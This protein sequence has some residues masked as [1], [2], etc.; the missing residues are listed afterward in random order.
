MLS[1]YIT[2]EYRGPGERRGSR[3]LAR[4]SGP[5][6][7]RKSYPYDHALGLED[8]HHQAAKALADHMGW[9]GQWLAGSGERGNVY[10]RIPSGC[11]ATFIVGG[12]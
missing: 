1:Q 10:V 7:I 9:T 11:A 4:T 8:N 12:Q 6:P 3:I 2:T 5:N